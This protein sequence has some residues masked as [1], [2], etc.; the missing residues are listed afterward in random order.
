MQ[1]VPAER[2]AGIWDLQFRSSPMP[3]FAAALTQGLE[4]RVTDNGGEVR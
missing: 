4:A 1:H 3:Q 2:I